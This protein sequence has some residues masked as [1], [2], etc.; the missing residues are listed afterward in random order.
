MNAA[1]VLNNRAQFRSMMFIDA[2]IDNA[3]GFCS[4]IRQN[5]GVA[6]TTGTL[7]SSATGHWQPECQ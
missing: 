1:Q 3:R 5:S 7:A 6:A 4:G 2:Q